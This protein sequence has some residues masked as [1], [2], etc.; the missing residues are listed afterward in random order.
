MITE[1]GKWF[2]FTREGTIEGPFDD[3][4]DAEIQLEQYIKVVNS[5]LAS[6]DE[7]QLERV[8]YEKIA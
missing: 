8:Q 5:G 1:N 3:A 2:F 6:E 7:L 4:L